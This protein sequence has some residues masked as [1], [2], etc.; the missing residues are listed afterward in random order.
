MMPSQQAVELTGL[1]L[2]KPARDR[3]GKTDGLPKPVS[4]NPT[5]S[6]MMMKSLLMTQ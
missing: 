3:N 2:G 4:H 1:P 6:T 5:A